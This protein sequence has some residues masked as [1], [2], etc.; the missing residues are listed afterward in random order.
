MP[1]W[2]AAPTTTKA[3][4]AARPVPGN[5]HN[6]G[7]QG[8]RLYAGPAALRHI[9]ANGLKPSDIGAI[10]A[11]AGGPKGLI[12]LGLDR[13]LFGQWLAPTTH[14]IELIGASIGAWR[15]AT[16]CL[17]D[18]VPAFRRL[19]H[20]YIHQHYEVPPGRSRPPAS[21]CLPGAP[22]HCTVCTCSPR[23]HIT[24]CGCSAEIGIATSPAATPAKPPAGG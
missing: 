5:R 13:F 23:N 2:W 1:T 21:A 11:A 15:M 19:E 9:R 6:R 14:R 7:M 4:E 22:P 10:P 18:P 16:A 12:L 17:A 24:K 20:D 3:P 8:L